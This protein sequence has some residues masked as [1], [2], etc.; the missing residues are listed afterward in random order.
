MILDMDII[1]TDAG[2]I[3]LVVPGSI[4]E[5]DLELGVRSDE[6]T[7]AADGQVFLQVGD[8]DETIISTLADQNHI[9]L[10]AVPDDENPP[11]GITHQA[12]VKDY[13]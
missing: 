11:E 1:M 5:A 3:V 8:I 7:L 12:G 4:P 9:D 10:I 2:Q 13:R 6:V